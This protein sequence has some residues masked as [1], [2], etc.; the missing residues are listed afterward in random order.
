[1]VDQDGYWCV[2]YDKGATF[3]RLMDNQG[4]P[5]KA[6][7]PQGEQGPQGGQG[8]EGPQ[9]PQGPQGEQGDPGPQGERGEDGV[10]I[11]VTANAAGYY[12]FQMYQPAHPDVVV[13][14]L[15]T[16]YPANRDMLITAISEDDVTHEITLTL[17]N[18]QTYVFNKT[19]T[20]P[21]SIAILASSAVKLGKGTM[22]TL[23]FRVN[24]SNALFNYDLASDQCQISLDKVGTA[25]RAGKGYVTP[26][27]NYRLTRVTQVFDERGVK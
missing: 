22:A 15:V 3:S 5:I 18:G 19:Y 16:P 6:Q 7:G 23:E 24:P 21:T 17:G 27:T 14:S 13:D 1:M 9:G 11:R 4:N 12:V 8:E 26:P 2:S 25:T 20:M 10:S